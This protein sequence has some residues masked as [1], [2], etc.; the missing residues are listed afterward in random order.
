MYVSPDLILR[1][2]RFQ[3]WHDLYRNLWSR[4]ESARYMLWDVT[5]SP[6]DAMARMERTIAFQAVHQAWIVEEKA[7]GQAIGFAGMQQVSPAVW[8]DIG[9][10]IGPEFVGRGYGKQI[11][12]GLCE[13]LS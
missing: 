2:P 13:S 12:F 1:K 5:R 8:E 7:S 3:D 11:I 10:A 9:I 4:E 6:E